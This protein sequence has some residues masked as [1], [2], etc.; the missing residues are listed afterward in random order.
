M[1]IIYIPAGRALEYAQLAANLWDGCVHGCLYCWSV[2]LAMR[3][4]R[5]REDF[6]G[7]ANPRKDV[8][9]KLESDARRLAGDPRP[10]HLCF[11]CDPYPP[12]ESELG[13][14]QQAIEILMAHGLR[15]EILTKAGHLPIRDLG[16]LASKP[17]NRCGATLTGISVTEALRWEPGAA[18]PWAR[19]D[20]LYAAHQRGISTK[21]SLEPV[22]DPAASLAVIVAANSFIDHFAVGKLNYH[23]KAKEIDWPAFRAASIERLEALG[24]RR[25]KDPHGDRAGKT[26]Y[27]KKDL[28]AA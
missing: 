3:Q 17:G 20:Y 1:S 23:P 28:E 4:G 25:L 2:L 11:T 8:L 12:A 27:V 24:F 18:S 19:L 21:I 15:V 16:L 10:V 26:Y 7:S 5:K 14:T 9:R 22:V 6:F 13:I